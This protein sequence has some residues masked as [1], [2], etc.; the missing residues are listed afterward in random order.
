MNIYG[1][2]VIPIALFVSF[3]WGDIL[4]VRKKI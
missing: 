4:N 1:L 2:Y 3:L